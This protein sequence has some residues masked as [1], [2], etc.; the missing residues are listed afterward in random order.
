MKL[1]RVKQTSEMLLQKSLNVQTVSNSFIKLI[2]YP[3]NHGKR[4]GMIRLYRDALM[5]KS[6]ITQIEEQLN[7]W[8]SNHTILAIW[9]EMS[10][11]VRLLDTINILEESSVQNRLLRKIKAY[12]KPSILWYDQ[13]T[14]LSNTLIGQVN[15]CL[16]MRNAGYPLIAYKRIHESTNLGFMENNQLDDFNLIDKEV[17]T[18]VLPVVEGRRRVLERLSSQPWQK[19]VCLNFRSKMMEIFIQANIS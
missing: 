8:Q 9:F 19:Q 13:G 7:D 15:Y 11:G 10:E 6:V 2:E 1:A 3:L 14:S 17:Q 18:C 16:V 4:L 12:S 5:H